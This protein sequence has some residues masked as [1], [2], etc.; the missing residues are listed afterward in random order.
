MTKKGCLY[1]FSISFIATLWLLHR[2]ATLGA[3]WFWFGLLGGALALTGGLWL[4]RKKLNG[5]YR[6]LLWGISG[7]L[8]A[9]AIGSAHIYVRL[10][11][12]L[13]LEEENAIFRVQ[14]Q[15]LSLPQVHDRSVQFQA[16]VLAARPLGVPKTL[17]VRWFAPGWGGPYQKPTPYEFPLVAPGQLWQMTVVLRTPHGT[18]N[19]Y[20][21]D[22]EQFAFAQDFRAIATVRG[23][24]KQLSEAQLWQQYRVS[25]SWPSLYLLAQQMRAQLKEV[26]Q[27]FLEGQRWGRVIA[28]LTIGD[29]SDFS[30]EDW[31][32]FNRAGLTHLISISGTHI[33]LVA[34]SVGACIWFGLRYLPFARALCERQPAALWAGL[35]T[36]VVAAFYSAIAGWGVPARRSFFMLTVA[37]LTYVGRVRLPASLLLLLV[38]LIVLVL[39]PWAML[40][41]GFWL[42]FGAVGVLLACA[43]WSGQVGPYARQG[44][45]A[46]YYQRLKRFLLWQLIITVLLWPMLVWFFAEFS[47]ASVISNIYAIPLL[48]TFATPLSLLFALSAWCFGA[49]WITEGLLQLALFVI[50]STMRPTEWLVAQPWSAFSAAR[51]PGW[52]FVASS[53]G[54]L[55]ALLPRFNRWQKLGWLAVLPVLFWPA[56]DLSSGQWRI[57]VLDVGQ[58]LAVLIQTERHNYLYDVG[59]RSNPYHDQGRQ[60]VL[61]HLQARGIEALDGVI[62]SHADLDHIGGLRSV[63][64]A[65][66]VRQLYSSFPLEDWWRYENQRLGEPLNPHSSDF[67]LAYCRSGQSWTV[68]GVHF[69][70]LW[71]LE[72]LANFGRAS[73][74]RNAASCVLRI[75]GTYHSA[76]LLGDVNQKEE[77]EILQREEIGP[78]AL[79]L[80]AHHGSRHGS[81]AALAQTVQPCFAAASTGWWNRFEHPHQETQNRWQAVGAL[82]LS[83]QQWGA[84]RFE[85]QG[86]QLQWWA[87][88]WHARRYWHHPLSV[89]PH[90]ELN[91]SALQCAL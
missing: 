83:T 78:T 52:A 42:S 29:R 18:Q 25:S 21:F 55:I 3:L 86:S 24:P 16:R 17:L 77:R 82:F 11:D 63:L 13:P 41:T 73:A 68:D 12:R 32:L 8:L 59:G 74:E 20:G 37:V 7:V 79:V 2:K 15:V 26:I 67:E 75:Q 85:S 22:Y 30:D 34:G 87:Q 54:L 43:R 10:L 40:S 61:P 70:F 44:R 60:T 57:E 39:D 65:V 1:L 4:R 27:P 5:C 9:N 69:Q 6:A 14:L 81:S 46:R 45:W 58:G 35:V 51:A 36:V 31:Q 80:V 49:H 56:R 89:S 23:Q 50:D 71:P 91:Q 62:I 28:A 84:L 38:A 88:R 64:S 90:A 53:L 48:G 76:L 19:P 33:T 66:P 72:A 47:V